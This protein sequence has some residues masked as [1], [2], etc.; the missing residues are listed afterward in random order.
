MSSIETKIKQLPQSA[1]VYQF[2]DA[3]EKLLYVGK[4]KLLKNRVKSYFR[5]TP[6][7]HPNPNLL[8]ESTKW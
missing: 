1:G 7:L 5:F 6:S 8:H 2:F 3:D 4:A